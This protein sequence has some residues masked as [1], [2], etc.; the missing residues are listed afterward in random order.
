M[1]K[2]FVNRKTFNISVTNE[3]PE[4]PL[5]IITQPTNSLSD[6]EC[7]I[8]EFVMKYIDK[9]I[10]NKE[11]RDKIEKVVHGVCNHLPKTVAKEC[12]DF[13]NNYADI[14]I[15]ILS[16]EVNPK[17]ACT[18]L[19]LCTVSMIKIQGTEIIICYKFCQY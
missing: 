3:I 6:T 17:E 8:C 7:V 14:V 4:Y 10:G 13:V 5:H 1:T 9:E 16:E 2:I 11:A 12:N 19:G 15:R 18:I